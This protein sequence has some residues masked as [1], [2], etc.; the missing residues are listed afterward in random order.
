MS[1]LLN[2]FQKIS[3]LIHEDKTYH[4]ILRSLS[5]KEEQGFNELFEN[6]T[7]LRLKLLPDQG[8]LSK[9][10]FYDCMKSLLDIGAVTK[11]S[12]PKHSQRIF[13]QIT[14]QLEE[15]LKRLYE[16]AESFAYHPNLEAAEQLFS[17]LEP[18]AAAHYLGEHA[19]INLIRAYIYCSEN[20]SL[21]EYRLSLTMRNL[22]I[23][24]LTLAKISSEPDLRPIYIDAMNELK[25]K[26]LEPL[27]RWR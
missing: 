22:E 6:T 26:W 4:A 5:D 24:G 19:V 3:S 25:L 27:E 12:D 16:D 2:L 14:P 18:C 20:P 15:N 23:L 8:T 7:E 1:E 21:A 17:S 10:T 13:Y 11:R 9:G